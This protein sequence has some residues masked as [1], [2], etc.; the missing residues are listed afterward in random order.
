M[1]TQIPSAMISPQNDG[2]VLKFYEGDTFTMNL[3][4][5]LKDQDGEPIHFDNETDTL[6]LSFYNKRN[7]KVKEFD[8]GGEG[9]EVTDDTCIIEFDDTVTAFFP[10]GEY[11]FD[12]IW[13]RSGFRRVTII[14]DAQLCVL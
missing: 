7:T 10:K 8:F 13:K 14:S 6:K 11:H 2:G 4:L 1:A 3:H 5:D 12:G 9:E